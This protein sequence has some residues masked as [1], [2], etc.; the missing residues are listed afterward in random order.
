MKESFFHKKSVTATIGIVALFGGVY[1]LIS[2]LGVIGV[3]G[4]IIYDN[5]YQINLVSLVGL[6]LVLCSVVLII[7]AIRKK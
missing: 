2:S 6:L 3:T 5:V 7:Y 1:F 4:N